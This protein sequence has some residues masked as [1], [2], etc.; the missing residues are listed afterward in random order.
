M[1]LYIPKNFQLVADAPADSH[2]MDANDALI[3]QEIMELFQDFESLKRCVSKNFK[4]EKIIIRDE[5]LRDIWDEDKLPKGSLRETFNAVINVFVDH[6]NEA[7]DGEIE[8]SIQRDMMIARIADEFGVQQKNAKD[9]LTALE[10]GGYVK[11][12]FGCT[13]FPHALRRKK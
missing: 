4:K 8:H 2:V 1:K 6:A 12:E 7:T 3:L 5:S 11:N 10:N 9:K 13:A